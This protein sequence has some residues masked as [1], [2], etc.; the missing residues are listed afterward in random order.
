MVSIV[1]L[2]N[3]NARPTEFTIPSGN[4]IRQQI[5]RDA[6]ATEST[7]L[8]DASASYL[9]VV[10]EKPIPPQEIY[11][12]TVVK[13]T[14]RF[15]STSIGPARTSGTSM[16]A[17]GQ[18]PLRYTKHWCVFTSRW[19]P[20]VGWLEPGRLRG[21]RISRKSRSRRI[22]SDAILETAGDARHFLVTQNKQSRIFPLVLAMDD[23]NGLAVRW[24]SDGTRLVLR[25]RTV[26]FPSRV[27][28]G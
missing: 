8:V 11:E 1:D 16:G 23:V 14:N 27:P 24:N 18:R 22:A 6:G 3:P 25:S 19:R 17:S 10:A 28:S 2:R 9:G 13:S 7:I 26:V 4:S 5:D 21:S 20:I 12:V 15:R